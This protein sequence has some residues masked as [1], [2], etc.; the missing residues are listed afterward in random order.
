MIY[1]VTGFMRSGTSAFM[2]G[3]EVG[4]MKILSSKSCDLLN[5]NNSDDNYK[6][7]PKSLSELG[8]EELTK[9]LLINNP[10]SAIKLVAPRVGDLPIHEYKVV[11]LNREEEEIRQSFEAA[12]G[13]E[14]TVEFIKFNV[15]CA[16]HILSSRSD[17][18]QII[19]VEHKDLIYE[20]ENVFKNLNWPIDYKKAASVIDPSFYRFRSERLVTGL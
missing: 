15:A 17:V 3:L 7:N 1:L 10:E 14:R 8:S 11:I 18:K 12:F 20:P 16:R 4:G 19:E 2:R 5:T 9:E 6:P 13:V